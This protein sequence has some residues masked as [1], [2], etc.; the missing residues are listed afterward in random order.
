MA[1]P[2]SAMNTSAVRDALDDGDALAN[3]AIEQE[4]AG[5]ELLQRLENGDPGEPDYQN[6]LQ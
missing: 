4:Q 5:K 1:P 3:K 2:V 6:A